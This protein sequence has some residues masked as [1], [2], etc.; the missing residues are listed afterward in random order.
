MEKLKVFGLMTLLTLLLVGFGGAWQGTGGAAVF[1]VLSLAM[2]FGMYWFSDK[3]VLKQYHAHTIEPGYEGGRFDELYAM[4]DRL[5]QRARLPM[6]VV[7]ISE[8]M[9]P[10]AFA[11]GRNPSHAVVCVTR[12]MWEL[13]QRNYMTMDELEGVMAHEL[14]HVKDRHMLIGTIAASMAG[15]VMLLGSIV[16][17]GALFG[18]FGGRD[19]RDGGGLELLALAILAPVAAMIVQMTI[20]RR[21][22]Y[23]ADADGA[24]ICGKP[25]ALAHA[26]EKIEQVAKRNPMQ[27]SPAA[28]H[29]A[30]INP[31]AGAGQG[32]L[33]LFRTHPPTEERVARLQQIA[34]RQDAAALAHG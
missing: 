14:A 28:S 3:I 27:V 33:S 21:N 22:E 20:S 11:T 25:L 26:L 34:S 4:I 10:N 8:Q 12:G 19:R 7:A 1:F 13:V 30:I 32:F 5:R 2:N 17:W 24:E 15:A 6:P 29:L 23:V 31:L 16:R 18:G 9:Q